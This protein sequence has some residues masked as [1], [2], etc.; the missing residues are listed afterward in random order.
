MADMGT[1]CPSKESGCHC[2]GE[3]SSFTVSRVNDTAIKA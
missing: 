1:D 2:N 3:L